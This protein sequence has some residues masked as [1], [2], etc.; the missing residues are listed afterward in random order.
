MRARDSCA[1]QDDRSGMKALVPLFFLAFAAACGAPSSEQSSSRAVAELT[2]AGAWAAPTPS[3]VDV[4]A[5]YVTITNATGAADHL[6]SATSPRAERV[7]VHE[8]TMDDA[9][10]QMRAVERLE[11]PAGQSVQLAPGGQHLMFYGVA[12]PFAEGQEI[13]VQLVFETSGPID[14]S[15]PVR[16]GAP[17]THG[18]D[19]GG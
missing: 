10:M 3:G 19:H 15:L 6:L 8:M 13:P 11:I 1:A 17:E 2:L 16:R 5:G 14:V 12:E 7:E 4:S 9:V 18:A